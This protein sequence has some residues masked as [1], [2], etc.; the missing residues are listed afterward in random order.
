LR[1]VRFLAKAMMRKGHQYKRGGVGLT[2]L[3][4][5]DHRH[6][7]LFFG[8]DE[9]QERAMDVLD[10]INAKYG[11]GTVGIGTTG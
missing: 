5:T 6:A 1:A 7:D 3:V 11:H 4:R 2:D 9:R 10:K 8:P